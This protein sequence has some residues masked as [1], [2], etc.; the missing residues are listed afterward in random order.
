MKKFLLIIAISLLLGG[1]AYS[2]IA[3]GTEKILINTVPSGARCELT[4]NKSKSH[5]TTPNKVKIKRSKKALEVICEKEG[6]KK[7]IT[8]LYLRNSKKVADLNLV[9]DAVI[10]AALSDPVWVTALNIVTIGLENVSRKFG[11]YGTHKK[12]DKLIII[13]KLDKN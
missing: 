4:N 11:T 8:T 10:S 6:F 5:V 2:I 12:D 1:N 13:I 9:A 7:T 3:I